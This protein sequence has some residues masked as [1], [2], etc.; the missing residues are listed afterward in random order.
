MNYKLLKE[1]ITLTGNMGLI[2]TAS[3]RT[4][5]EMKAG[6][7]IRM[8]NMVNN[9]L[10]IGID[11]MEVKEAC[12]HGEWMPFLREIGISASSAANYMRIAKEVSADSAMAR[13]PYTKILALLSAPAE[14]REEL[15][16][17][18]EDMSAAEIR[19][20]TEERNRAAE[21]ANTETMRADQAEEALRKSEAD[22]KDIYDTNAHLRTEIQTLQVKLE[23]AE[24]DAHQARCDLAKNSEAYERQ[25]GRI[26]ELKGKLLEA[27]N[28]VI[29][30]EKAPADYEQLKRERQEL[31][32]AA[33][34]AEARA[35]EA[36]AALETAQ[37]DGNAN[38]MDKPIGIIL[39][40]AMNAFFSECE[41][42]PFNP[43]ELQRDSY[44]V[45]HCISQIHEW[46]LRMEDALSAPVITE[47]SVI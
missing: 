21:A 11:L 32:E 46:C 26:D 5:E 4:L 1:R 12:R 22:A 38:Q 16:A 3:G 18:A 14:E 17:A 15:A 45:R 36:E 37:T 27:E 13:L 35:A 43:A 29:E 30:V 9:A 33:A 10:E 41:M 24:K 25:K 34:E 42:M 7:R 47:A 28:H 19:R 40:Q 8:R 6:I 20:L 2:T 23:R 39:G 44:A 31:I